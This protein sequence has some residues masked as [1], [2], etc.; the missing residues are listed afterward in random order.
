MLVVAMA[1]MGGQSLWAEEID[2]TSIELTPTQT[3]VINSSK[4]DAVLY[5]ESATSWET[6]N[7]RISGGKL[8]QNYYVITKFDLSSIPSGATITSANLSF[9]TKCTTS[10][11]NSQL[12]IAKFGTSWDAT[13]ATWNNTD[14]SASFL[15]N[16][17]YSGSTSTTNQNYNAREFLWDF[18]DNTLG[19]AIYTNSARPQ[20]VSNIKLKISY[21][22][23]QIQILT[24]RINA[25]CNGKQL[26]NIESGRALELDNKVVSYPLCL[27]VNGNWYQANETSSYGVVIN[28][29]I[30]KNIEYNK[31]NSI[32][33]FAE[34]ENMDNNT[35]AVSSS[36]LS[37]GAY[38]AIKGKQKASLVTL[39]AG[40][41]S[42]S[43]Y[44]VANGNRGIFVRNTENT[45]NNTNIVTQLDLNRSSKG[46]Y[47]NDFNLD[48]TTALCISGYTSSNGSTNQSADFD[49]VLIKAL[50]IPASIS[51]AEFATFVTTYPVVAPSAVKA[52]TVK[53]NTEKSGIELSEIAEGTVIPAGTALLLN[54]AEGSYDF[55]VS[56][57]DAANITDNDLHAATADVT[58]T[59][60]E[61]ALTKQ[62]GVVGFAPVQTGVVIPA[63]KAYLQVD[64]AGAAAA[65]FLTIGGEATGINTVQ[66]VGKTNND[67]YYTLQGV[68][69]MKPVKGVYIHNGKK[70]VVNK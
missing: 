35:G 58:A 57:D 69:T 7:A 48:K 21:T 63:G 20:A 70:V 8:T 65:K 42:V 41:Y 49:Y 61:Y 22:T 24:Y 51:A 67:A 16:L 53:V 47:S 55:A 60:N 66:S 62:N 50:S 34:A 59:G 4:A 30:N 46:I 5:D 2:I 44:V 12:A 23:T 13:T 33:F 56:A 28:S 54:A 29:A 37:N 9:D 25:V 43:A 64:N 27:N 15:A 11:R 14:R 32:M 10:G 3:T 68:K 39:P 1:I 6:N 18:N 31:D 17:A 26:K 40:S 19:F 45:D 36:S 38:S 52:Y